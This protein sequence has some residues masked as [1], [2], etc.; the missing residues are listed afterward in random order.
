MIII[1]IKCRLYKDLNTRPRDNHTQ[2]HP[3]TERITYRLTSAV[4]ENQ[5]ISTL[6]VFTFFSN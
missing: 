3:L 2:S 6:T 4:D 1:T 5:N